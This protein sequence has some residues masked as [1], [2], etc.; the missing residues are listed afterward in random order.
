MKDWNFN[1]IEQI[2]YKFDILRRN[3][4]AFDARKFWQSVLRGGLQAAVYFSDSTK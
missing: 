4:P 3:H 1:T 2:A